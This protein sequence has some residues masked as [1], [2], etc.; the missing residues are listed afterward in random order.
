MDPVRT[1]PDHVFEAACAC[2][3]DSLAIERA[4]IR[5]QSRLIDDLGADSLDFVDIVFMLEQALH[6]RMR[7]SELSFLTKLDFS[8]PEVMREGHLTTEVVDRLQEW[9]PAIGEVEDRSRVT[10]AQLFSFITV[11]A[12]CL[13]AAR[14]LAVEA[15][16]DESSAR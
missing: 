10:P 11:E 1:I 4:Q 14:R 12:I 16:Q 9:L 2:I 8:S 6:V 5:L 15:A 13:A 3:A 7:D